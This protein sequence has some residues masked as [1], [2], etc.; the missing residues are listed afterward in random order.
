[1]QLTQIKCL[2]FIFL[3][4]ATAFQ[5]QGIGRSRRRNSQLL[6]A[7]A[8]D[9]NGTPTENLKVGFLGCGT[10]ASAIATGLATQTQ[11]QLESI[12][13]T[14]RSEAKSQKL[15][16]TFPSLVTRHDNNQ[17]ILNQSDIVFCCV[18]PQQTSEILQRLDFDKDR[19]TLVSLVVSFFFVS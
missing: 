1:M 4:S 12:A 2:C 8:K 5:Y 18:L 13:V 10:I 16:E 14:K 11:I 9:N 7:N 15:V 6:R 17:D 19:H 3:R